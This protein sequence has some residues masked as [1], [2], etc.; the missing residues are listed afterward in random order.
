[1]KYD[2]MAIADLFAD[3]VIVS[4]EKP[5]FGQTEKLADAYVIELGGSAPIFAS[6][7]AKLGGKVALV[8]VLGDDILGEF[9]EQRMRGIG[10]DT[11]HIIR[12]KTRETPL[13]LNI[14]VDGDR[15]LLTVL[16]ALMEISPTLVSEEIVSQTRHWHIAGY[17]LL[18]QLTGFWP[19]FLEGLKERGIT[20]SLDTNWA[21]AGNWRQVMELLPQVNVFLPNE[22]EAMAIT[23][24]SDYRAAGIDLAKTCGLVVV[25]RGADGASAFF[26]GEEVYQA[27]PDALRKNL[28]VVDTTGAGDSFDGGF[29][30]EWLRKAPLRKCLETGIACGTSSV[31]RAGGINGQLVW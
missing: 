8:S 18:E 2:V 5:E 16:G 22:N 15:S 27:V 1:M 7:F 17:F 14:S 31:Q 23:G 21:P 20:V 4:R 12:S 9:V 30:F 3:I 25:K 24:R 28:R 11:R 6:Q 13:G 29:I 19:S 26:E 10:I